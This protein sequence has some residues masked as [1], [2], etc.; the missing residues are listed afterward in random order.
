MVS[1]LDDGVDISD[2]SLGTS[3]SGDDIQITIGGNIAP[4]LRIE[5]GAGVFSAVSEMKVRYEL[6]PRLYMQTMSGVIR[7]LFALS[8][9]L[10]SQQALVN[11]AVH[12]KVIER[13]TV[14]WMLALTLL[15]ETHRTYHVA[16]E[17][18][19]D[20]GWAKFRSTETLF[21]KLNNQNNG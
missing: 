12:Q 5:Y 1:Y 8:V 4:D 14:R 20:Y 6:I 3:G 9:R 16:I 21:R 15:P 19:R 13:I 18:A 7:P 2:L 10:R 11:L 17:K